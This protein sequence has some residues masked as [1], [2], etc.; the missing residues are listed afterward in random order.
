MTK[1][2]AIKTLSTVKALDTIKAILCKSNEPHQVVFASIA[3]ID[4]LIDQVKE[5]Y[6]KEADQEEKDPDATDTTRDERP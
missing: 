2:D 4:A 5:A 6:D 3:F 1:P